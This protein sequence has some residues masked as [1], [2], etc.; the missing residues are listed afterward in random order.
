M[1]Q[2]LVV[3]AFGLVTLQAQ[4]APVNCDDGRM[5]T[6]IQCADGQ[7]QWQHGLIYG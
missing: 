2:L 7:G 1:I 4:A 3:V 6:P 5:T